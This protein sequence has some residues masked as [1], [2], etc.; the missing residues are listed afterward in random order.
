M[1]ERPAGAVNAALRPLTKRVMI[2]HRPVGRDP[3]ERRGDDEHA[4]RDQEDP[5]PPE[6]VGRA[7]PEQQ[8]AAV[9][10]HVRAHDPLQRARR[11]PQV[12]RGSTE[13]RPR[14]STRRARRGRGRRRERAARPARGLL[15]LR[16]SRIAVCWSRIG[17]LSCYCSIGTVHYCSIASNK[18]FINQMQTEQHRRPRRR[19]RSSRR[20]PTPCGSRSCGSWRAAPRTASSRC[21]AVTLPV[22]KSTASHHFKTLLDAGVIAERSQGTRKYLHLR[23]EELDRRFPELIDSVLRATSAA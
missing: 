11:H 8:E 5:S 23:R 15:S 21:G 9:A 20:S 7:A 6:Q 19:W 1:I 4:E 22:T 3:A 16:C 2:E 10:E 18:I 14:S 13:A 12:G 17:P